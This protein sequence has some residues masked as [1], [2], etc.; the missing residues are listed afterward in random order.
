[1]NST[2]NWKHYQGQLTKYM[3]LLYNTNN[4]YIG[5]LKDDFRKKKVNRL[6]SSFEELN[7]KN[8]INSL[9][10]RGYISEDMIDNI[11]MNFGSLI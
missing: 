7:Y 11:N 9:I 3:D 8:W 1:M 4:P 10:E 5:E 6:L 2:Q